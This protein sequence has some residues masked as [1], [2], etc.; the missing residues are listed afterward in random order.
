MIDKVL[1]IPNTAIFGCMP[2]IRLFSACK[3]L[4]SFYPFRKKSAVNHKKYLMV[5]FLLFFFFCLHSPSPCRA[6]ELTSVSFIPQWVPQSQFA[7]YFVAKEQGFYREAGLNVQILPG[8]PNRDPSDLLKNHEVTFASTWLS[9]AIQFQNL[10][11][12]L[13]NLSQIMQNTALMLVATKASG[14]LKPS[15]LEGK[16][17]GIWSGGLS[18]PTRIFLKKY[19]LSVS[20]VP[21]YY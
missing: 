10:D 9:A 15:D 7:G 13:V 1:F 4:N 21:Q 14:I 17:V 19:H 18:L 5:I 6:E 12:P 16:R 11:L 20:E 8:G 3:S 2:Q